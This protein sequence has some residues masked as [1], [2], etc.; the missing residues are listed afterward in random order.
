MKILLHTRIAP[1]PTGDMHLGT[2]RTA[3]FNWL[4]AKAS[5]GTFMLRIDDTDLARNNEKCVSDI[6]DAMDWL[7]LDYSRLVRQSERLER[8]TEVAEKLLSDGHAIH[9]DGGAIQ[10]RLHNGV[11][12]SWHDE[13]AGE[14]KISDNDREVVN[15]LILI[16][17]DGGP[18]YNFASV[19]DDIDFGINYIIR[20]VDHIGNTSKQAFL[21]DLLAQSL[22]KFAHVGLLFQNNKKLSKRDGAG[23]I[24]QLREAGYCKEAV[25]NFMLRLCWGPTVDDKTTSLLP[26]ECAIELFLEHGAMR[27]KSANID[28]VKLNSFNRKYSG[29]K[30]GI[31]CV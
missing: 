1:S 25:L 24:L 27:S 17:S 21:F 12:K 29:R 4:A 14:I 18:T 7:G 19:V 9:I 20:G 11:L 13:I 5:G 15:N 26:A 6:L 8:Y 31:N 2:A 22:P 16:K 10:F 28:V 30:T 23:S 3:Y